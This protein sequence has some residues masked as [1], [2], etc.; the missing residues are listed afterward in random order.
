MKTKPADIREGVHHSLN[1]GLRLSRSESV[2]LLIVHFLD[3]LEKDDLS[4]DQFNCALDC[5]CLQCSN[6]KM[7]VK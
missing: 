3:A 7:R 6:L 2:E 4:I 5:I 1:E